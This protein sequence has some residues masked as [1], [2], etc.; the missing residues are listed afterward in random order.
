M[1]DDRY[2]Y[3]TSQYVYICICIHIVTYHTR[4]YHH[5]YVYGIQIDTCMVNHLMY[6]LGCVV[7]HYTYDDIYPHTLHP[8]Y[9][10]TYD[11]V[12][13]YRNI[14]IIIYLHH[15]TYDDIYPHTLHPP[16]IIHC[17]TSRSM[18]D[19]YVYMMMQIRVYDDRYVYD[20]YRNVR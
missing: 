13:M 16:I 11:D 14:Y 6:I 18:M 5:R 12:D 7:Y 17:D 9:H 19:R 1:Y 3:G 8:P 2:V 20:V 15:H 10:H 4:I